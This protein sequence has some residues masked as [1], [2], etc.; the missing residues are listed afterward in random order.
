MRSSCPECGRKGVETVQEGLSL[1]VAFCGECG[2][3][4]VVDP[5]NEFDPEVYG[6]DE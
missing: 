4:P 6:G 5:N 1:I 3:A 2:S